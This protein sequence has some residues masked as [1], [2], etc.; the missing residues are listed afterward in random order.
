MLCP[1]EAS[2]ELMHFH[3][4]LTFTTNLSF[5]AEGDP[6]EKN[7]SDKKPR[8]VQPLVKG[9]ELGQGWAGYTHNL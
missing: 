2:Q 7:E 8:S 3:L 4:S 6:E 5:K 9:T 1:A